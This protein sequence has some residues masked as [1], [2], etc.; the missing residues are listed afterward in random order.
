MFPLNSDTPTVC[1]YNLY[2]LLLASHRENLLLSLINLRFFKKFFFM[3]K[4]KKVYFYCDCIY[5]HLL[6]DAVIILHFEFYRA[7]LSSTNNIL[8]L[9]EY[10]NVSNMLDSCD[11]WFFIF[12][13][14]SSNDA[15]IIWWL[16]L[17]SNWFFDDAYSIY[18]WVFSICFFYY[19]NRNQPLRD[20]KLWFACW[21]VSTWCNQLFVEKVE[22]LI[23]TFEII[24]DDL[25]K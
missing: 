22:K 12:I 5:Y 7:I 11:G 4:K 18:M 10:V 25:I 8:G 24:Q 6:S 19:C 16:E 23:R 17:F 14:M 9:L 21:E 2:N 20:Y 13:A 15:V 3:I 1:A